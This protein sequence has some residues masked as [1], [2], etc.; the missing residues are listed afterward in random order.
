[1]SINV[2]EKRALLG[3]V[4]A[5]AVSLTLIA[6]ATWGMGVSVASDRKSVV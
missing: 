1:M 6:Y 3:A 4:G 2:F 5:V